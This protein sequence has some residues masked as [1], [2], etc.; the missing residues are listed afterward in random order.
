[1]ALWEAQARH[2]RELS[3]WV[4]QL[5]SVARLKSPKCETHTKR[6]NISY[7]FAL[8]SLICPPPKTRLVPNQSDEADQRNGVRPPVR[9]HLSITR[10]PEV[11]TLAKQTPSNYLLYILYCMC[12][13]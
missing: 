10:S 7:S 8:Y 1:M 11:R 2:A 5:C 9:S 12:Y 3:P 4:A 6:V 13:I